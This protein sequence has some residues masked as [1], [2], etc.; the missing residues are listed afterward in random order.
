MGSACHQTYRQTGFHDQDAPENGG[1]CF[2]SKEHC[3][4]LGNLG[5]EVREMGLAQQEQ[6]AQNL[7]SQLFL[8]YQLK[9]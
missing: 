4:L 9:M 7:F 2:F 3:I 1:F 8:C 5:V 6:L